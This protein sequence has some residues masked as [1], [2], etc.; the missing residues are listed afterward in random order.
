MSMAS[1]MGLGSHSQALRLSKR[2][3]SASTDRE[4]GLLLVPL[5]S[6]N[7]VCPP[8]LG[9][10]LTGTGTKGLTTGGVGVGVGS[11]AGVGKAKMLAKVVKVGEASR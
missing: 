8:P 5:E 10:G 2:H 7:K 9:V 3:S 4:K 6:S 11:G 1:S